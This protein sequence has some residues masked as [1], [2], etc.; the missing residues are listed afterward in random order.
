[1]CSEDLVLVPVRIKYIGDRVQK[2]KQWLRAFARQKWIVVTQ[3]KMFFLRKDVLLLN[4]SLSRREIL[5][6]RAK[7]KLRKRIAAEV[8]VA[9]DVVNGVGRIKESKQ[10][11]KNVTQ[12]VKEANATLL[13]HGRATLTI[14]SSAMWVELK[15]RSKQNESKTI[16]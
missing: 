4:R 15:C 14:H 2:V 16:N 8:E 9:G 13:T 5:T 6:T 11:K 3:I 1:M 12:I 10:L 7:V